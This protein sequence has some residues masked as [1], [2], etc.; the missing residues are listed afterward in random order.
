MKN[1]RYT[2][3]VIQHSLFIE[4]QGHYLD[5]N[6]LAVWNTSEYAQENQY[7]LFKEHPIGA[8]WSHMAEF[9][10]RYMIDMHDGN[11]FIKLFN[12]PMLWTDIASI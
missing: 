6:W 2:M 12:N 4:S 9:D 3:H 1:H 5:N 8:D 7:I 10:E 11:A